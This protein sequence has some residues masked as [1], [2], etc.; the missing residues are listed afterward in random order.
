MV[1]GT[2]KDDDIIRMLEAKKYEP[3]YKKFFRNPGETIREKP[4]RL[5]YVSGSIALAFFI[6]A[7]FLNFHIVNILMGTVLISIILPGL[8]DSHE[9]GRIRKIDAEFPNMLRDIALS[10]KSGLTI[11]AAVSL[12]AK[13]EYGALTES[14]R[15]MDRL[16]SWG[17]PFAEVL[18]RFAERYP[19]PLIKRSI[20][21]IIEADRIGGN[22]GPILETVAND[23][24]EYQALMKK[25]TSE[26]MPYVAI[27]Y[28]SFFIFMAV[29]LVLYIQFLPMMEQVEKES[30]MPGAATVSEA[31]V[32]IFRMIFFH[33]LI[34]QGFCSGIVVGKMSEG[35]VVAGLIHSTIL[36]IIAYLVYAV[37]SV[38]F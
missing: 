26:T 25:R 8:Y 27:G 12:T 15:W 18:K 5:I 38:Y 21:I 29:I 17:M 23:A 33:A 19:T 4:Y 31:D 35:R 6:I 10:R 3:T 16:L 20:F 28:L 1:T 36:V 22:I 32:A 13:G 2:E 11:Q 9:K 14:L 30:V 37:V 7:F 24:Q 34:V